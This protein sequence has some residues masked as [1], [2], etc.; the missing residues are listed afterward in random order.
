MAT[1]RTI[2]NRLSQEKSPY[3]RQHQFNPV[4]WFS[5]GQEALE[6]SRRENKPI[7]LSIGYSSCHW[8]HV[9]AHE[10]FEDPEIARYLNEEFVNIKVDRE[11][12]P[13][14][15]Q[16]YQNAAQFFSQAGG[17]PLTVF[18]TPDLRP[19]FAGTYFPPQNSHGRP[20]FLKVLKAV[21][22]VYREQPAEVAETAKKAAELISAAEGTSFTIQA[23]K[24]TL[25]G[26]ETA[27]DDLLAEVDWQKGGF[28]GALKFPSVPALTF[29]WYFGL[30]FRRPG[31][32]SATVMTLERMS[33]GGIYDQIGGGF[34]R[35]SVDEDW[36]V[37]HF[38]KMLYDNALL[39]RLYAET[40]LTDDLAGAGIL[41]REQEQIFEKVL[42]ET[43]GYV[44]RELRSPEGGFYSSQDADSEGVEG[45]FYTWKMDELRSVLEPQELEV[46]RIRYA[47]SEQGGLEGGRNVLR[48]AASVP[49]IAGKLRLSEEQVT[50]FLEGTR[51][52]MFEARSRRVLPGLDRKIL[53]GWNGLMIS[54]LVWA[55]MAL[56]SLGKWEL[57][58]QAVRAASEAYEFVSSRAKTGERR[59]ARAIEDGEV[60][61]SGYLDDYAF[62]SMAALDLARV[63]N[64]GTDEGRRKLR[65]YLVDCRGW[66]QS[67]VSLFG[68]KDKKGYF[69]AI[70]DQGE[71][72][73]PKAVFDQ[74]LPSGTSVV[75]VCMSALAEMDFEGSAH[76]FLDEVDKQL[77]NLF[78]LAAANP[79]SSGSL[80]TA[81]LL[82]STGPVIFSGIGAEKICVHPA[83]FQKEPFV[84]LGKRL[85]V[86]HARQCGLPTNQIEQAKAEAITK[87]FPLESAA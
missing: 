85:V 6:K 7:H 4:D 37:P 72:V 62:L 82:Q 13:D 56:R 12:R 49:E 65:G 55:G 21:K 9:M 83:F 59:L 5:W 45:K 86:C 57:Y 42:T 73:R 11:E 1:Q 20:G 75:L 52:K 28:R 41:S 26:L 51:R 67:V 69:F 29:L 81:A 22:R 79:E 60:R 76:E 53:T 71:L 8:C 63:T 34:C 44:L 10:S 18:L 78:S 47:L 66:L 25:R 33:A 14:L 58:D 32:R 61:F 30:S 27:A 15:D 39:L 2:P 84:E 64:A 46:A 16:I 35:Y 68:S 54:G 74:A 48:V 38:E 87:L 3:L 24:P 77:G 36:H 43:V 19:F 40:L 80:L 17:W 31:A 70:G 50:E 23:V